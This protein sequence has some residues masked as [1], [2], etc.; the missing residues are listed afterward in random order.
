MWVHAEKIKGPNVLYTGLTRCKGSPFD[1]KLKISGL[2]K[3][4]LPPNRGG[5][6]A[7]V[8]DEEALNIKWSAC[9]KMV[10]FQQ[11]VFGD[12]PLDI[13]EKA[14]A[15]IEPTPHWQGVLAKLRQMRV[16]RE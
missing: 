9:P 1:G 16:V 14:L 11:I 3:A 6:Y 10:V 2:F 13:Y 7:V 15:D 8:E 12:V 4:H 5:N